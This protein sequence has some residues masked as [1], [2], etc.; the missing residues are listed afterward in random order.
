MSSFAKLK[1]QLNSTDKINKAIEKLAN[2]YQSDDADYW[3]LEVDKLSNGKAVIRFL[4]TPPQDIDSD[5]GLPFVRYY[6]HSFK[7]QHGTNVKWYI[8]NCRTSIGEDDPCV[9]HCSE[10]WNTGDE[11]KKKIARDRKR[12]TIYVS[13]I[14]VIEDKAKPENEGKVFKFKYGKKIFEKINEAMHPA[15]EDK[16]PFNPFDFEEG[17]NFKLISKKKDGFRNYDASY[18][19][20]PTPIDDD[21]AEAIYEKQFSLLEILDPKNF[22]SYDDLKKRLNLT[23]G[24]M[25]ATKATAE[26]KSP[27]TVA[28]DDVDEA[29]DEAPFDETETTVSSD[30]SDDADYL[31]EFRELANS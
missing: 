20:D 6:N 1:K 25:T 31:K 4:P 14:L 18:F 13:N 26:Y 21:E 29:E 5:D 7:V 9:E 2:P 10:L 16:T 24:L 27:T 3:N 23:L 8:E 15:D 12:K 17:A 11:D 28:A 22:K 19:L 30:D